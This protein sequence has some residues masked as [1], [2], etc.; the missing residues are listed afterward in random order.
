MDGK[1][2]TIKKEIEYF[3]R[4][5]FTGKNIHLKLSPL[6]EDSGIVFKRIDKDIV[7][8]AS[9][10]NVKQ[11]PRCTSL[12]SNN[13][14]IYT[15]E[16][17]LSALHSY[18]IDNVLIEVDG[19]E[20]PI[21]DGSAKIFIDLIEKA[22]VKKQNKL[23]NP[24]IIEKPIYYSKNDVHLIALPY[25][26][27]KVSFT[28]HFDN[29]KYLKSQYFSLDVD[30]N[31]FRKEIALSR[32]F[33]IYEEIEPLLRNKTI[34]GGSLDCAIVIKDNKIANPEGVRFDDEMVRHKILDLIGDLNLIGR[35]IKG[36][37]VAI[38][39]GHDSNI[40]F[41][42]EIYNAFCR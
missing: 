42:R 20:I 23:K 7:I 16:H 1:Q 13:N 37:I 35:S 12:I 40:L 15:V 4:G 29:S 6:D 5:L 8:E 2:L 17:I 28:M 18:G 22:K 21:G 26:G 38:R 30:S 24:I 9:L 27:F 41:A 14:I 33:A 3:G 32:T 11:T 39:S 25:D 36:H 10:K 31:S 34:M 19:P